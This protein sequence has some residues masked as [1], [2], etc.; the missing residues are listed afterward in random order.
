MDKILNT[1]M[2][3]MK[4]NKEDAATILNTIVAKHGNILRAVKI[5]VKEEYK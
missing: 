5:A 2:D 3:E 4:C 1:I